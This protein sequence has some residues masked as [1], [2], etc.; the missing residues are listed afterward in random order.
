MAHLYK[1]IEKKK[2]SRHGNR[3]YTALDMATIK[4]D[5]AVRNAQINR[6]EVVPEGNNGYI[7][8]CGCGVEGCFIHGNFASVSPEERAAWD[9]RR[10]PHHRSPEELAKQK[11]SN[12]RY[13]L[14]SRLMEQLQNKKVSNSFQKLL[15]KMKKTNPLWK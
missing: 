14:S 8:V 15:D 3:K 5:E 4:H 6:G 13:S 2:E 10:R 12:R 9:E 11:E 7:S 1:H